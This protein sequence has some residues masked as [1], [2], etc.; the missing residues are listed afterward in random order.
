MGAQVHR[1]IVSA[2]AQEVVAEA[3]VRLV[4]AASAVRPVVGNRH[5]QTQEVGRAVVEV[6]AGVAGAAV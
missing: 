6:V 3:L 1:K 4:E 2:A 5:S